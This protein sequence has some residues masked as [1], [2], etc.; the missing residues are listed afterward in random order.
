MNK[1][2]KVE[3]V[4]QYVSSAFRVLGIGISCIPFL[5][6]LIEPTKEWESLAVPPIAL[7]TVGLSLVILGSFIRYKTLRSIETDIEG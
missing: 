1:S 2:R 6:T 7:W 3:A 4:G 5:A